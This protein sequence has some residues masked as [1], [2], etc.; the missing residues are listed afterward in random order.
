MPIKLWE[1]VVKARL[2]TS[3]HL[4]TAAWF[5]AKE[6]WQNGGCRKER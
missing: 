3:E 1:R 2:K 4:C 5:Y 6:E